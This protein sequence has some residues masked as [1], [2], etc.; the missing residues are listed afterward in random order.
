MIAANHNLAEN[1]NKMG[2]PN[3]L[4][5]RTS[6]IQTIVR[7]AHSKSYL[8]KNKYHEYVVSYGECYVILQRFQS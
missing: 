7:V 1:W 4:R 6:V 8:R 2:Q 5:L 3:K